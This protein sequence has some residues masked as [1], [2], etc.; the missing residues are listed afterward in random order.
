MSA[1]RGGVFFWVE[2]GSLVYF[3][4]LGSLESEGVGGEV[5][6]FWF[7]VGKDRVESEVFLKI[8]KG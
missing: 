4:V 5:F 3:L 2:V 6:S 7:L 1:F 8:F